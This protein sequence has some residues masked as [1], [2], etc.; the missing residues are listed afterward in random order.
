MTMKLEM[1]LWRLSSNQFRVVCGVVVAWVI[2]GGG[3]CFGQDSTKLAESSASST[4]P[5]DP[6]IQEL[7]EQ[8]GKLVDA[9]NRSDVAAIEATFL[10]DGELID[11]QGNLH[12][13]TTEIGALAK[14]YFERFPGSTTEMEIQSVR[15]TGP[16]YV[17]EGVRLNKTKDGSSTA[18]IRFLSVWTRADDRFRIV[19]L[20]DFPEPTVPSP[21][22]ML[23][24]LAWLLGDWVNE[25]AD[26]RVKI[27]YEWS[28]DKNFILGQHVVFREGKETSKSSIRIA[29]DA[30]QNRFRSW[31]F[32]SDGG[33]GESHWI[34]GEGKW[35]IQSEAVAIDGTRGSARIELVPDG[36]DRF[37]FRGMD[38]TVDG[39][40]EPDYEISV[41]RAISA[42][43]K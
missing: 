13:G 32:D 4:S 36:K 9:F 43:Q 19:T 17:L 27:K 12:Q 33:F 22:E 31:T 7:M 11:E 24:S 25:G 39:M 10:P 15:R 5:V 35:I 29:W 16:V 6:T 38:R 18:S 37:L 41:V 21:N 1:H 26:G 40:N 28:A 34:E 30:S 20:R 2:A 23:Q 14:S 8:A 3:G 42:V